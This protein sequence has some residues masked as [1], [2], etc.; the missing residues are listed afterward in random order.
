MAAKY[1]FKPHTEYT[2]YPANEM[3]ERVRS[4]YEE[5]QRRRTIH[6]LTHTPGPMEFLNEI[7]HSNRPYPDSKFLFN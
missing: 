2:K 6:D 3:R 5:L 4:F 7:V 1:E